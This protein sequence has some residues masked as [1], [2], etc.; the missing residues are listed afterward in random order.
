MLQG[1]DASIVAIQGKNDIEKHN[2]IL[3]FGL[4]GFIKD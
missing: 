3:R 2:S 4:K 1:V